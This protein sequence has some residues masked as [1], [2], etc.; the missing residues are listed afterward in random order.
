MLVGW[1]ATP[2]ARGPPPHPGSS[3]LAAFAHEDTTRAP[4]VV[5]N[6]GGDGFDDAESSRTMRTLRSRG[7]E[8][9]EVLG[10]RWPKGR[11]RAGAGPLYECSTTRP[12]PTWHISGITTRHDRLHV[13]S[14]LRW[15]IEQGHPTHQRPRCL[16]VVLA[17][18][19]IAQNRL[20]ADRP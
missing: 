10:K 17:E 14:C 7:K 4:I 9:R 3:C 12:S 19:P 2:S 1:V 6:P 16:R 15:S 5:T 11:S 8:H 20:P 13:D 18:T